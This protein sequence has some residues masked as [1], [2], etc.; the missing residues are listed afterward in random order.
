MRLTRK[1][2]RERSIFEISDSLRK[3][4][5][6]IPGIKSFVINTAGMGAILTGG[7]T[8]PIEV[9]IIG[10]NLITTEKVAEEL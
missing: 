4:L 10:N 2:Q 1:T 9:N 8:S 7:S 6:P 5:E 3:R